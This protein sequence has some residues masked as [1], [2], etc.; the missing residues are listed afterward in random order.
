[1]S[2][3]KILHLVNDEKIINRTI[4]EFE[5]ATSDSHLWV[6][7]NRKRGFKLVEKRPNVI[8]RDEFLRRYS[9]GKHTGDPAFDRVFIHLLN[10][11]KIKLIKKAGLEDVKIF[12]IIWGLD[13]YNKLL[14]PKGFR[15][16]APGN[17]GAQGSFMG[18]FLKR[19][20]QKMEALRTL[21]FVRRHVD[22]IVTDTTEVDYDMLVGYY[23][24]LAEKPWLD[25]FY[26]P[27]DSILG[28]ELIDGKV[29]GTDIMIGNSASA[30]NNHEHVL[31]ILSHLDT[32]DR[33][34]VVPLSYSG[35]RDY[36]ERVSSK[37]RKLFGD[38]FVP[39]LDFMPLS[40][41]NRQQA[42]TQ[43]AIFGN[44]RQE[45]IGNIIIALYLGAKVF[46]LKSNPVYTW[47]RNHGLTV[48]E[49]THVSDRELE[50][51]L[52][53]SA[54][55]SNREILLSLYT[56]RRMHSLIQNMCDI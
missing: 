1:M 6:V 31:D 42:A 50:T 49:L 37:G 27:I 22:Y 4:D 39:L 14:V 51:P 30:T 19:A 29:K 10:P 9:A 48:F 12:W 43:T 8:G 44:L 23:P 15:M 47:A 16:F 17:S 36:V 25:F 54:R 40:E 5:A 13:L 21:R 7:A 46:L 52:P 33:R 53:A 34:I 45:A 35:K 20:G 3:K 32:G 26:Y 56:R 24:Q 38:S 11:R 18:A 55:E 2:G 41:Y 28:P